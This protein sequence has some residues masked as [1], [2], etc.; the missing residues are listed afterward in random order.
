MG[1][2]SAPVLVFDEVVGTAIV[3][4]KP[5]FNRFLG[6]FDK[7][8]F[9]A[10]CAP[11]AGPPNLTVR[12]KMGSDNRNFT[13]KNGTAEIAAQALSATGMQSLYGT[14]A[15]TVV[16]H[17]LGQLEVSLSAGSSRIQIYAIGRSA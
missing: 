5:E 14:D 13:N 7:Y 9:H 6:M 16:G 15:G 3:T 2:S 4:T 8:A 12:L 17:G 11:C 10:V 1:Q